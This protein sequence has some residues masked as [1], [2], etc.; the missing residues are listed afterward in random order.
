MNGNRNEK[1]AVTTFPS[2]QRSTWPLIIL[3]A[4]F[5]VVP[6]L[7]WYLTWFGRDLSDE[8]IA[9]YLADEKNPRHIQ[10]AL[11]LVETRIEKGESS[12]KKFYPQIVSVSKSP[13]GEIRK[14]AA[15]VMG[16]D[17]TSPEFHQ[18]LVGLLDD[19]EPLVR[20]NAALQLVRFGDATGRPELS[21]MLQ[22]YDVKA[23][24]TGTLVSLL[25]EGSK[26]KSGGLLGRIR[27]LSGI[28][29]EFRSPLD[30]M[31]GKVVVKEGEQIAAARTVLWLTPD[32]AT[33]YDALRA[34]A[35]VGTKDDLPLIESFA[36][37]T[38]TNDAETK[39]QAVVT[40]RAIESRPK[41]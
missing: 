17:N 26:V 13:T 41:N 15:W 36:Q 23:P 19:A 24:M 34:L 31:I 22:A 14:T 1:G 40:A 38:A 18:A 3:A 5:I 27:D 33:I 9:K 8:E 37:G 7:T 2:R 21:A 35:Y 20:R 11:S 6:F 10:H 12:V 25:S 32:R 39:Q 29:Q 28:V 30:G 16:Q 4:L